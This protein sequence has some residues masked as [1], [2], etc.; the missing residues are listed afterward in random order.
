[1][2]RNYPIPYTITFVELVTIAISVI[3]GS[4]PQGGGGSDWRPEYCDQFDKPER[5]GDTNV[6]K[7]PK[8]IQL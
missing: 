6:A 5:V 2:L 7:G 8:Q 4:N 3:V 1:M